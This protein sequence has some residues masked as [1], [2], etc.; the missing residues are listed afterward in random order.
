MADDA[1][2][3]RLD[4][5][6]MRVSSEPSAD[7]VRPPIRLLLLIAD[8]GGGHR[9]AAQAV[10]LALCERYPDRFEPVLC[11]P[12]GGPGSSWLLRRVTGLYG[13]SI[14]FA[15]WAWA[16]VYYGSDSRPGVP[17][18]V[19]SPHWR[20]CARFRAGSR[21]FGRAPEPSA[22]NRSEGSA[23]LRLP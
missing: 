9:A 6:H 14:R 18:P 17:E 7:D 5:G 13:P 23:V 15:R 19:R 11:D 12:L 1:A 21:Q 8:T 3:G 10:T 20:S 22:A 4:N 2:V 16:A